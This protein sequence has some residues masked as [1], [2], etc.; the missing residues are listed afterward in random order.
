MWKQNIYHIS[1][2]GD[3]ELINNDL[4][5]KAKNKAVNLVIDVV[6]QEESVDEDKKTELSLN[7]YKWIAQNYPDYTEVFTKAKEAMH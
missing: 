7:I 1:Y 3:T 6:K 4:F 2:T 5:I